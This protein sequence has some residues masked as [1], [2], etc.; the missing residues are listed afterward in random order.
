[1]NCKRR[2][3][4]RFDPSQKEENTLIEVTEN[5]KKNGVPV[6]SFLRNLLLLGGRSVKDK[7]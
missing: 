1:M 5:L 2:I 3:F 6:A 4:L 7:L